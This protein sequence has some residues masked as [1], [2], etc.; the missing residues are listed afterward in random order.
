MKLKPMEKST[1]LFRSVGEVRSQ[2][3]PLPLRLE[4]PTDRFR[5]SLHTRAEIAV[6]TGARKG[7]PE[8]NR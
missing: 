6:G 4:S 8:R 3:T 2:G 7:K 5:E 1:N